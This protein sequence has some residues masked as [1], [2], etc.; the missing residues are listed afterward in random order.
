MEAL[1]AWFGHLPQVA[2]G[3]LLCQFAWTHVLD[4]TH[5]LELCRDDDDEP[6]AN[7]K[8]KEYGS[9]GNW[10]GSRGLLHAVWFAR[11]RAC[12]HLARARC[13]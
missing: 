13:F 6:K 4:V 1:D 7:G 12:V 3:W 10:C 9:R 2:S 8:R 5:L 11:W